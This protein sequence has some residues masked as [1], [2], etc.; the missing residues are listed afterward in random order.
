MES[1]KKILRPALES[2]ELGSLADFAG[3]SSGWDE[4]VGEKL[5]KVTRPGRVSGD[6]LYL[7]VLDP[8]FME[9]VM[10]ARG[11]ILG[12]INNR[13]QKGRLESVKV[14]LCS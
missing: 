11:Q 10:Y 7:E 14:V 12:R 8:A 2:V 4:I 13:L 3:I 5:A 9:P 1:I 6:T